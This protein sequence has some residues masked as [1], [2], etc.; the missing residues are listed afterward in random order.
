KEIHV[1]NDIIRQSAEI[2]SELRSYTAFSL[3][4]EVKVRKLTGF[5]MVPLNDRQVLGIK[6]TDKGNVE[7][8]VFA[9]PAAVSS[10]DLE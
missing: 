1:I 8:L 5:R 2:Q 9:I 3:G 10:H 4:P 7:T 6:V